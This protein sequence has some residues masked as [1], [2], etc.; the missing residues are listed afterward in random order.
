MD[1]KGGKQQRGGGGGVMNWAIG[2]DMLKKK[3]NMWSVY[4]HTYT[5]THTH[6]Q[7]HTN[8]VRFHLISKYRYS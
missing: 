5:Q 4:T 7:T 8:T 3:K 1:T 6:T 2:I